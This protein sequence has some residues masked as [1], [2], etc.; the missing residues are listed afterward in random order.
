MTSYMPKE[1]LRKVNYSDMELLYRW[2]NDP[3]TRANAFDSTII[4]FEGHQ[5]WFKQKMSSQDV[6]FFI[7]RYDGKDIG[8]LRLDIKGNTAVIDYSVDPS[9]RR[10]GYGCR[11]IALTEEKIRTEYSMI[12]QLQAQ[13]KFENKASQRIFQ[14]LNYTEHPKIDMLIFTKEINI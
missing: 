13:V 9:L 14:K 6:L 11:M 2:A 8:Q 12:K 3:E 10:K 7:Y 1:Y 5:N 4:S